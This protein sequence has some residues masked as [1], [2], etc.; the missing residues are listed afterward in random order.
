MRYVILMHGQEV[1]E[2]ASCGGWSVECDFLVSKRAEKTFIANITE[3]I[4][5]QLG[6][7]LLQ[8]HRL[9]MNV[10]GLGNPTKIVD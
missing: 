7:S 9:D 5:G 3:A 2:F 4:Q 8:Q 10:M 6:L 1:K